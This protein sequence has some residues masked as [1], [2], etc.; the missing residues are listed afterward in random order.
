MIEVIGLPAHVRR[1]HTGDLVGGE[2][3]LQWDVELHVDGEAVIEHDDFDDEG[4]D[5]EGE[6]WAEEGG[7]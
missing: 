4:P 2:L 3:G 6:D 7:G 5:V 1:H